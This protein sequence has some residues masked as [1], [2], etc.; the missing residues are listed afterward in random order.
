MVT[1]YRELI[2]PLG[3]L[4]LLAGW[5]LLF[6]QPFA[7][8]YGKRLTFLLSLCGTLVSLDDDASILCCPLA[9]WRYYKRQHACGG[10]QNSLDLRENIPPHLTLIEVRMLVATVFG[11]PK[12]SSVD[13]SPLRSKHSQRLL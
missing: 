13:S 4:F 11:S 3:Y 9:D 1:I 10:K 8:R 7:L 6:W 12:T 5:G 2:T